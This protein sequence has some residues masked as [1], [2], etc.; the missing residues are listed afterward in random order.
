V[1]P[2]DRLIQFR[3]PAGLQE[4]ADRVREAMAQDGL[5][6]KTA[7]VYRQ[8]LE[9]GLRALEDRYKLQKEDR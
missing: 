7:A 4:R 6:V 3:A 2:H 1:S 9:L 8:A 5:D